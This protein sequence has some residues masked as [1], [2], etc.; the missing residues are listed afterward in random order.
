M[1][2]YIYM[3][4]SGSRDSYILSSIE[5]KCVFY[6]FFNAFKFVNNVIIQLFYQNTTLFFMEF[7]IGL[8]DKSS[9]F[10]TFS[11]PIIVIS[12]TVNLNSIFYLV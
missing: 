2:Y 7:K 3:S 6:C 9:D 4:N 10:A 5:I 8:V 12:H 1:V 11:F